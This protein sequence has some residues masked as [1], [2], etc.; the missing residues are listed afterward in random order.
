LFGGKKLPELARSIGSAVKEYTEAT[1]EPIKYMESKTTSIEND[2]RSTILET[3]KKMSIETEG[4]D[5][6]DIAQDIL[7]VT[8]K[9]GQIF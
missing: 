1:K 9:E 3:A 5:I 2:N 6:R 8:K 7:K 4:I